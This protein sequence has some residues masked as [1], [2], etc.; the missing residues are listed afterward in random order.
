MKQLRCSVFRRQFSITIG[1]ALWSCDNVQ[2][3][4]FKYHHIT[5]QTNSFWHQSK[6]CIHKW[7]QVR[8]FDFVWFL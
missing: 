5:V 3:V 2:V 7:D 8:K 6:G 4:C 1:W